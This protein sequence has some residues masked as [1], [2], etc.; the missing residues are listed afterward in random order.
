MNLLELSLV[1]N[2]YPINW[3][4]KQIELVVNRQIERRDEIVL[5]HMRHNLFYKQ[6]LG[7]NVINKFEDL[8][9]ITKQTLQIPLKQIISDTYQIG[10]LFVSNTSGSSGHPFFFCKNKESHAI[11]HAIIMKLYAQHGITTYDKQARFY[12]IPI[13]GWGKYKEKLKD[14]LCNRTR[15]HVFDLSDSQ[16]RKYLHQFEKRKFGYIYGYTS[17]I[18]RFANFLLE[19]GIKLKEICPTLKCCVVTSEVCTIEDRNVIE[20]AF[21]VKVIN[22]YGCSEV[23]L[24]AFEDKESVWRIVEE[25]IY[26]EIVDEYGQVLPWG[27]EGRILLTS[28]SN[29]AM[30]IIRYEVG[31]I[32]IIDETDNGLILKKL[33]GRV[34]DIIRLPSGKIAGGLTFYYVARTI[35]EHSDGIREFIV[36][37]VTLDTFVF[38]MVMDRELTTREFGFL[39]HQLDEYLAPGLKLIINRVPRIDRP[40]SGKIK[41]FYSEL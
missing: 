1:I 20:K 31:D 9:I 5:Y 19:H 37:Q 35:L 36:R 13:K 29:K 6:L 3:A 18:V 38:D 10:E 24:I 32:G 14:F 26:I 11:T 27:Q 23:G 40:G 4:K 25:D 16:F 17:A 41:H 8:P 15:F 33:S 12:G 28:L 30:P 22:E 39:Q 34:S 2:G 21:G 7:N